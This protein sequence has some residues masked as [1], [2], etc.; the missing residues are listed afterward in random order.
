MSE[1]FVFVFYFPFFLMARVANRGVPVTFGI[2]GLEG[3]R[4]WC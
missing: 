1:V 3:S 4:A 2:Q